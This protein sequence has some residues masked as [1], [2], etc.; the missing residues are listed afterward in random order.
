MADRDEEQILYDTIAEG[1]SQY[2]NEEEGNKDPNQYLNEEGNVERDAEGN[3]E[4]E[5]SGS[6]PSAGQK[7]ARGQ[8]EAAKNYVR[9]SGW[10]VRDN[11][12]VS[13]VYWR[14]TRA[15]GDHESFV[16]DSEK[17]MLWTTMFKTFTLLAG[18]ED[19]TPNFDTFPKLRDH[20]DE[21][22]AYKT[23]QQGSRMRSK[24][25]TEAKIADLEYRVSSYELS[26]QEEVARKVDERMAAHRSHDPQPTIPPAMVSPSGNRSSC[27]STR[28]VESQ[29]MDAMQTQ[30]ETTCPVDDIT[31]RTPCELHIPFK[32]LSIKVASGMAIPTDPSGTYHCRPILA[33]YS[34]VEVELVKGAYE[35]LEL[36]YPG[37]DG[38]TH[39]RD[40]SHAIILW[41]KRYIILPGR[42]AASRAPSPPALPY[43][44]Q[45]PAP[46]P[47]HAPALS[48][49]QAPALTPPQAPTPTPPQAPCPAPSKSRAP[50]APPPAPTRATKK[51]KVDAAKNKDPGGMSAPAKEAI[52]QSDYERTLKKASSGKANYG[53][54]AT[55]RTNR[56]GGSEIHGIY[57]LYQLDALDVSI[58][59]CWIL[60]EIQRA[61]RRGVFDTGFIDPRKVNVAMLDQ[62]PQATEDNLVHLLKAQHYKTFILL[63]YNTELAFIV[64]LYQISSPYEHAKCFICN[65]SDAHCRFHWVLLLFDL[66]ACTVNVNDSMDKKES[67]FDKVFELI[68]SAWYRFRHLVRGKWREKFNFPC[69]K[70]K[71]GTNL[72]GY[73][74][75]EYCHCLA[76]QI[77]TTRELDFI[78]MRDNLT[79]KE[80]IAAVQEQLMGFIN[81]QILNPKGEFYYNR[82]TIH[83]SL[84][85]EITTSTT[86]KLE[87][88]RTS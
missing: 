34:K 18:T 49:P 32:N 45:A 57:E 28:Q 35:D 83:M 37:G 7:R 27:A 29:S 31:Q 62:Y 39:L 82:N 23:G 17:E 33:G 72:C 56:K 86:S 15:R 38:E 63:P 36:D 2:W 14:R 44:P 13:T 20:W 10:V 53:S 12:P 50:Q 6:Q 80:F 19:K 43:P 75:C 46:S 74:V 78:H 3:E 30:D 42:Q 64:F 58:M 24:R 60:M 52:K 73:Y 66:E 70:Q 84:A 48:P 51:A 76:D 40:T 5:A 8:R 16:P 25:D 65:A 41:R 11:V 67:T 81:E 47:P 71:Q 21:Y 87:L 69:A 85:S 55:R 79:H 77:I 54:I 59:S 61:R 68:D 9:H 88:A 26:M 1:S 22:V 4:E